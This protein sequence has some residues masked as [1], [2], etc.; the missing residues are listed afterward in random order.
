VPL[1][2]LLVFAVGL[3]LFVVVWAIVAHWG[4]TWG[5]TDEEVEATMAGD[6][7]F[8]GEAPAFLSMTR[9]IDIDAAP[10][11]VWPWLAQMGRGAG[12][13]SY[14]LLD[15]G[16]RR[17]ALHIV[18]W[19]PEPRLGD[20]T[21][22]GYLRAL[23]PGRTMTW[24]APGLRYFGARASLAVD[25]LLTPTGRGS[26]LVIRMSAEGFGWPAWPALQ[27][28]RFID[29][30]MAT[31]QLVRFKQCAE[32]W[33]ART[34][35]PDDPETRDRAQYQLYQVIYASND[36][37]GVRGKELAKRWRRRAIEAGF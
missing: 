36:W 31:R 3:G 26:R 29:S 4:S 7:F 13:Y 25:A 28:F 35:N 11:I 15:N 33:G 21:A 37:A 34:E 5:A 1:A 19:I 32:T 17:S 10:D 27:T 16:N 20:A 18:S 2:G 12:W 30:I 8:G 9:A 14:D 22:I 23:T 24:W 6:A